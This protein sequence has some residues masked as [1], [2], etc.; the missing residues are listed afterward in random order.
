LRL[1]YLKSIYLSIYL[2]ILYICAL[3]ITQRPSDCNDTYQVCGLFP[4][5][6]RATGVF[7]P[8]RRTRDRRGTADG[9]VEAER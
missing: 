4:S 3:D 6:A 1:F 7:I 9:A 2:S 5:G 8:E